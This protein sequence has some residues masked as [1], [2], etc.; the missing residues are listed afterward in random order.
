M[1]SV[2]ESKQAAGLSVGRAGNVVEEEVD[3][4]VL[5]AAVTARER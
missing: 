3:Y 4:G 2:V 5:Q 1:E